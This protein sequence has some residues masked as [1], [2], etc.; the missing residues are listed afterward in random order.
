MGSEYYDYII[1]DK[2]VIPDDQRAFYAEQVVWLPDSD[3]ANDQKRRIAEQSFTRI[4][5]GLPENGFHLL[6]IQ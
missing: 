6:L 5:C 3:Q 4:G 1:A 2:T